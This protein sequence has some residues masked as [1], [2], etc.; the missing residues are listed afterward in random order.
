MNSLLVQSFQMPFS[1]RLDFI[2]IKNYVTWI[3]LMW[4]CIEAGV[5]H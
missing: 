3:P 5:V 1:D 4:L 2:E